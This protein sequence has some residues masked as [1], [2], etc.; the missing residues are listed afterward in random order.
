MTGE[1]EIVSDGDGAIV[2]GERSAVERFLEHAGLLSGAQDF[3]ISKLSPLLKAGSG[4]AET[5]AE[6]AEQSALYLKLTPESAQRLKDAG[7]LMKTK[8]KGISHAMLGET[9]KTSLKWLQVE[10]GPGS[11]L[12]NP[13]VLSGIGGL[14]SQFAQQAEARE[15]KELLVRLDEK[16][17]DVR[18]AQ[19]DA[20]LARMRSSAAAIDE[21]MV[22]RAHGGDPKTTWDKVSGVSE[23]ILNV[24][25][26]ALLALGALADKV[27]GKRK[28]GELKKATREIEREVAVQLAILARCFE[29][30]DEFR[31]VEIDHVLATAPENLEG[32][33]L[34]VAAARE[35]RQ[36]A[37]VERTS[38]LM[39]QMDA[40]GGIANE[41]IILHVGAA[42]SVIGALNS[43]AAA[44]DDFHAPLG[45]ESS[46]ETL[47]VTPWR[48]ALR[49]P[50]QRATAGKE[51]SQ[52]ALIGAAAAGVAVAL[53]SKPGSRPGA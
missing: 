23:S 45:I 22:L 44:V 33:R 48:E 27:E 37:V 4:I 28:T 51:L 47:G 18:R 49:D 5:A 34:G 29:L 8:T 41:H 32:H 35:Q 42:R 11:L 38:R 36:S 19:R 13:A 52:K 16:L 15:L 6:V 50:Q 21:A 40:A 14:M 43:T 20:V 31:V 24:Q 39:A 7:G 26:E 46:R 10:D 2:A 25:E 9:G 3:S 30:Q 1:V 53:V 12:T 17:D